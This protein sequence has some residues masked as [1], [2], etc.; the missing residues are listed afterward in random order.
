LLP[1]S[2]S[3]VRDHADSLRD[4]HVVLVGVRRTEGLDVSHLETFVLP[5]S[6]VQR[7][8]LWLFGRSRVLDRLA[9]DRN[10]V[11]IHAHFA[12]A[13]MKIAAFAERRKLPLIVT[14]HGADVLRRRPSNPV[15][16]LL[17]GYLRRQ[18]F[19]C[20]ALFLPVSDFIR[21]AALR[22]G[23][24]AA[25]LKRHYLGIP[26]AQP[27]REPSRKACRDT[28]R[29]LFIGRL[30]AKKGLSYL[31]EACRRLASEGCRINLTVIGDGPLA[32]KHRAEAVE[33]GDRVRF[34]GTLTPEAVRREM[35]TADIVCMPSTEADDGDNEGLPIV[36]LEAQATGVP[37]VTFDQGPLREGVIA[38]TTALMVPDKS[39][40]GLAEAIRQLL[41]DAELRARMGAAGRAFV[42]ERFD[43]R[44]RSREL[45]EI[46]RKLVSQDAGIHG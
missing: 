19:R 24:P 27:Q 28:P 33:L 26:L 40:E 21:T 44:H 3:F 13:G 14:L 18:M 10:V 29:L 31:L 6:R 46:Y 37:L 30:V 32:A 43:I 9:S 34:A 36:A 4:F 1:A 16:R 17:T 2:Q 38:G 41:N 12:D 23:Y 7:I 11:A 20:A 42:N 39:V 25:R 8:F 15:Q 45:E 5:D 35:A 22:Q